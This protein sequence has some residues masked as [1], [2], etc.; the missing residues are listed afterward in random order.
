MSRNPLNLGLR[1]LLEVAALVALGR[2]GWGLGTGFVALAPALLLPGA[3]AAAWGIF[4][5][6]NDGGRPV[7]EVPGPVRLALEAAYFGGAV[8]AA[9]RIGD[10]GWAAPLGAAVAAHYALSWDRVA[11]LA[12]GRPLPG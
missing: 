4:R 8:W 12:R 7:V 9:S 3:A 1:F 2:W 10:G 11:L 5:V 6:P